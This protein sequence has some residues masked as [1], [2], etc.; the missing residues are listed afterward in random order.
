VNDDTST[1]T[2]AHSNKTSV[3]ESTPTLS[4]TNSASETVNSPIIDQL[5]HC[6]H[7]FLQSYQCLK[8]FFVL[9]LVLDEW[10]LWKYI[11][12]LYCDSI[13]LDST[14]EDA[15]LDSGDLATMKKKDP[16]TTPVP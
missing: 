15:I 3:A 8:I 13:K 5:T 14:P 10:I 6:H 9:V 4:N 7:L 12:D 1:D 2:P 11:K 16:N